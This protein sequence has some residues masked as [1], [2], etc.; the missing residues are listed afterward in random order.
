MLEVKVFFFFSILQVYAL[1]TSAGLNL[2]GLDMSFLG[3]MEFG[4]GTGPAHSFNDVAAQTGIY[5]YLESI[6]REG[7]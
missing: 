7:L 6:S 4:V 3:N 2:L 5:T 1:G